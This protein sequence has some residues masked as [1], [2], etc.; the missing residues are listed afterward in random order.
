MPVI[1]FQGLGKQ[2]PVRGVLLCQVVHFFP[3]STLCLLGLSSR[4]LLRDTWHFIFGV[5]HA[6]G[7][8]RHEVFSLTDSPTICS[9]S[10]FH[11]RQRKI[12][13]NLGTQIEQLER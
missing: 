7:E 4:Q 1:E 2:R 10:H 6:E 9:D 3:S 8:A 12:G 13:H 11:W 5:H